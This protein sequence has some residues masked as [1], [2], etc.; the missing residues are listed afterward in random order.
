MRVFITIFIK[1]LQVP[2]R[3]AKIF[4]KNYMLFSFPK[5]Y[6]ESFIT[7]IDYSTYL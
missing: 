2:S 5:L 6:L 1:H 7:L 4:K 3:G